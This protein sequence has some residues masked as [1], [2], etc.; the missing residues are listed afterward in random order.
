M[1]SAKLKGE[2][3]CLGDLIR[4]THY[5]DVPGSK[6]DSIW[7]GVLIENCSDAFRVIEN[8]TGGVHTLS[9]GLVYKLE[10]LSRF[11]DAVG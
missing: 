8:S 6:G 2:L 9:W 1:R 3:I 5:F 11:E 10:V 7:V 4:F